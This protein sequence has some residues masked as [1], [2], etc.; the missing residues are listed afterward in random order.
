VTAAS[1]RPEP[2]KGAV[3]L[4]SD[5]A[6]LWTRAKR[7]LRR[8]L[9]ALG[10][11]NATVQRLSRAMFRR[12]RDR[13]FNAQRNEHHVNDDMI[14]F[15][16]FQARSYSCS[17]KAIYL[18]MRKDP[19]FRGFRFV[20]AFQRPEDYVVNPDMAGV[21][22]VRSPS[23]EYY[24]AYVEAKYWVSNSRIP[25][26]IEP[27]A[28]QVYV[29]TWHGTPLKRIG[30]DLSMSANALYSTD[31]LCDMYRRDAERMTLL[32]SPS[33]FA[34][35]KLAS[36]FD[37][38][39]MGRSDVIAEVGY[40]RNDYLHTF[41]PND[42]ERIR[43]SLDLPAGKKV[44]LY[45]PTWRED[46]HDSRVGYVY[47]VHADFDRM[48]ADL[49]DEYV[50]L[51][52]A[53]YFV[54]NEFDFARYEGFVRDVS[55]VDDINELYI[56]SDVLVTDYSSVFFD[57]ANLGRP[58][59]FYMYDLDAYANEMR[60]FY[61]E[62]DEL[63]GPVCRTEDELVAALAATHIPDAELSERYRRFRERFANLDDGHASERVIERMLEK[64][65]IPAGGTPA[66]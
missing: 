44:I 25:A 28:E 7:A 4:S 11:R 54:S 45:A 57:Y 64:A 26:A 21:E 38:E 10:K 6:G 30:C 36:A 55:R 14:I 35:E 34:S 46:Q 43:A 15:E 32:V 9:L 50:I 1:T 29:Q 47:D 18:A 40:P 12:R 2:D 58:I 23:P 37:L 42:A 52:R 8:M 60:G 39:A 59:V 5:G 51:F 22:L 61:L 62:L 65:Q 20:W 24:R 49:A 13:D 48:R 66:R 16:S 3:L 53:H 56:V 31:D 41:T 17:P 27:T 19:R 63:P 33:R